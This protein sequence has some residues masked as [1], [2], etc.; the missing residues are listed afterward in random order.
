MKEL[1]L[2]KIVVLITIATTVLYHFGKSLKKDIQYNKEMI[3]LQKEK[4]RLEIELKKLQID[5]L[6]RITN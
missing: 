5:S 2:L 4:L 6:K 3:E 1:H